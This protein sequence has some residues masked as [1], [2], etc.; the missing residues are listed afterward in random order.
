M[1]SLLSYTLQ[2][3]QHRGVVA[4]TGLDVDTKESIKRLTHLVE[5]QEQ[6]KGYICPRKNSDTIEELDEEGSAIVVFDASNC[7]IVDIAVSVFERCG[8]V[9]LNTI[10]SDGN[11]S[12]SIVISDSDIDVPI[13]TTEPYYEYNTRKRNEYRSSASP[14]PSPSPSPQPSPSPS[15]QPSPS[16]SPQPSPSPSPQPS[17]QPSP[18]PSPEPSP[19]PSPVKRRL[20]DHQ[21]KNPRDF[22]IR[23]RPWSKPE[24]AACSRRNGG[25]TY[26]EDL[27]KVT[28]PQILLELSEHCSKK[29]R[30]GVAINFRRLE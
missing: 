9:V 20:K 14:S 6:F 3:L 11:G 8:H 28:K 27:G 19:S 16:P 1:T 29:V 22:Y 15:P 18:S 30:E 23:F 7:D 25:K 5:T 2:K 24:L 4:T 13:N 17:P 10:H 12:F 26:N 21:R